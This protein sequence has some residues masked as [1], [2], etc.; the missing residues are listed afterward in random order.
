M[1]RHAAHSESSDD[2]AP[3]AL[4]FGQSK[5]AAKGEQNARQQ[6]EAEQK[7][8]LKQKNRERDRV[9]KE[10]AAQVKEKEKAFTGRKGRRV[11]REEDPDE[12]ADEAPRPPQDDLESRMERAMREAAEESDEDE[13]GFGGFDPERESDEDGASLSGHSEEEEDGEEGGSHVDG[14]DAVHVDEGEDI[15]DED[16]QGSE[17][18]EPSDEDA[19]SDQHLPNDDYLPDH[20][21]Q[22]AFSAIATSSSKRKA[23]E[24]RSSQRP[25]KKRKRPSQL[26][27]DILVGS[28]TIRTLPT[29]SATPAL[30]SRTLVPPAPKDRFLKRTLNLKGSKK[31]ASKGWERRAA[32]VGIMKRNGPAAH[33]VRGS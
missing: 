31:S 18:E 17:D 23:S 19:T 24:S 11:A 20:L 21:F 29:L 33:F 12:S 9:L 7:Q 3:E 28:R 30:T 1:A 26:G 15:S 5:R 16:E 27:R 25:V 4:S 13:K 10:R 32:N 14:N 22:D 6:L 2:E 8:K